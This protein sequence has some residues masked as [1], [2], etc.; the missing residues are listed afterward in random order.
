MRIL[1]LIPDPGIPLDGSKGA[2]VHVRAF[3]AALEAAGHEVKL[4]AARAGAGADGVRVRAIAAPTGVKGDARARATQAAVAE[5][6]EDLA[7]WCRAGVVLERLALFPGGGRRLADALG[8]RHVLEVNAPLAEEAARHRGLEDEAGARAM[9]DAALRAAD[10]V[11]VVSRELARRAT[12]LRG[13]DAVLHLP[14]GVELGR[15]RV[16]PGVR[17]EVRAAA[18][19]GPDETVVAFVGTLK[20]WH[21]L[22]RLAAAFRIA[23]EDEPGLRLLVV[24]D[25]PVRPDLERE[26]TAAGLGER[27]CFTGAV[28]PEEVARWLAA[29]DVGVAPY[30]AHEGFYFSPLKVG[31]YA[32][33]GLAVVMS[34]LPDL[35]DLLP[36]P[37]QAIAVPPDDVEAL[38]RALVRLA[39]DPALRHGVAA[40]ALDR[41]RGGLAWSARVA[42]F[43]RHLA[44]LRGGTPRPAPVA[45]PEVDSRP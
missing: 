40:A 16:E 9:E 30:P 10:G 13:D 29:A 5:H 11:V 38:S 2:A 19:W 33:A 21:G 43:E 35:R 8:A 32:A 15:F 36:D 24:G 25:G 34:D 27:T 37:G 17:G 6:V 39:R 41:A 7:R 18:G 12:A 44:R 31:E 28:S 1:Y 4:L 20:P 22:D 45:A 42:E 26:L 23:A 14:N 3:A